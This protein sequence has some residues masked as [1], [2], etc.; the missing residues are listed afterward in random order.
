MMKYSLTCLFL[1]S[2]LAAE[3]HTEQVSFLKAMENNYV[4]REFCVNKLAYKREH[5]QKNKENS[6]L[7]FAIALLDPYIG[8]KHLGDFSFH[9]EAHFQELLFLPGDGS[10]RSLTPQHVF[11]VF[12]KILSC[13]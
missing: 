1:R 2:F 7:T 13:T 11:Q 9:L 8:Q 4:K 3:E 5:E 10:P 12:Y 6:M